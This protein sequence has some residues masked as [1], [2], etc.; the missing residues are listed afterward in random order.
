MDILF[1]IYLHNYS[2]CEE[3]NFN[4]L[5]TI[6]ESKNEGLVYPQHLHVMII[7]YSLMH[8]DIL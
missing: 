4:H 8:L 2:P 6:R 5:I 1:V 7:W 3:Y